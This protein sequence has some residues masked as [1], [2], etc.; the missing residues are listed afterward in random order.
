MNEIETLHQW[1][2]ESER[3]VFFGGA[4]VS[5]ESGIPDFRSTDGLYNQQYDYPPEQISIIA[6]YR[7]QIRRIRA[8]LSLAHARRIRP[9]LASRQWEEF[10]DSRIA[11][12]DSFQGSES[13][14]VIISYVR[15]NEN[16][17]IGFSDNPNRINVAHTRC[18]KELYVVGDLECL[19]CGAGS[20]IFD[21]MERA[22]RRDGRIIP[23]T[24]PELKRM[25]REI[26]LKPMEKVSE[27]ACTPT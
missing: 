9:G 18:R 22:F 19:K 20:G 24:E 7:K 13:D 25:Q 6:P 2:Q 3:V 8:L 10:L 14:A 12:V 16:H 27:R 17:V 1:M 5:T 26:G 23:L 4:G 21:Q 15:S 11:T